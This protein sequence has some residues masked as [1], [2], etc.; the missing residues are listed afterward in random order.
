MNCASLSSVHG[1]DSNHCL[2]L[3]KAELNTKNEP[4]C[5]P[6][7]AGWVCFWFQLDSRCRLEVPYLGYDVICGEPLS[8]CIPVCDILNMPYLPT[9]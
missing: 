6:S 5:P 3:L 4:K 9:E 7:D 1:V 8:V 2:Y